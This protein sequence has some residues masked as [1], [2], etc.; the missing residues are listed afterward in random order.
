MKNN[1]ISIH[2]NQCHSISRSPNSYPLGW[3]D[4]ERFFSDMHNLVYHRIEENGS[5]GSM[6]QTLKGKLCRVSANTKIKWLW[7]HNEPK[8]WKLCSQHY[9]KGYIVLA[10]APPG[11]NYKVRLRSSTN[12]NLIYS[13]SEKS[14]C[15]NLNRGW[16]LL[17]TDL[18][19][20]L[21][22]GSCFQPLPRKTGPSPSLISP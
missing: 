1:V 8:I 11:T 20:L 4:L 17:L 22:L 14:Q 18:L 15:Y 7:V 3:R 10:I 21:L 5:S 19:I 12:N 6:M 2:H 9:N 13:E 16:H